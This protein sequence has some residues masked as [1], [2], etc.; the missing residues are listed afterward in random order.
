MLHTLRIA[1]ELARGNSGAGDQPKLLFGAQ[2]AWVWLAQVLNHYSSEVYA[3]GD[4]GKNVPDIIVEAVLYMVRPMEAAEGSSPSR[5]SV[6]D[7]LVDTFGASVPRL[8]KQLA[9]AI[10]DSILKKAGAECLR[11]RA[12][13][14]LEETLAEMLE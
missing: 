7:V 2:Y 1:D 12:G 6:V 5:R 4:A 3:A 11:H 9:A 14:V 13:M 8:K 10:R